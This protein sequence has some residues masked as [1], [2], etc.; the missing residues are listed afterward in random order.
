MNQ[1]ICYTYELISLLCIHKT[2]SNNFTTRNGRIDFYDLLFV[3][4]IF[5]LRAEKKKIWE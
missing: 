1:L 3:G 2:N 5:V 4:F